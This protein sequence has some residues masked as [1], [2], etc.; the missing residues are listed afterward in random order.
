MSVC[1]E[2]E[3]RAESPGSRCVTMKNDWSRCEPPLFSPEP[4][5]SDTKVQNQRQRAE[6]PGPSCLSMKSEW[7]RHEPI[8]FSDEPGATDT[9]SHQRQGSA[10]PEPGHSCVSFKSD[11]SKDGFNFKDQPVSESQVDQQSSEVPSAQSVQQHQ[12]HLNSIFML[13]EDNIVMFVK[14]EV[15]KIQRV[16]SPD[17]PECLESQREDEEELDGEDEEQRRSSRDAFLKITVNFLRR[18]KQEELADC[19]QNLMVPVPEPRPI[20][21]YQQ[22]LQSNLQDQFVCVKPGWSEDDQRLD[23]IYTDLYITA[24]PDSHIN[25][26][27]E[28]QQLETTQQKQRSAEEPVKPSDL[29]KH[30]PGKY[31][32]IRTVLTNGIAGIGKTV[33]V[34]KFVLDWTQQ[35]SNQ[36]VHLIFPFTFRR[37]N[38]LKGQKFSLS[39]LIHECI[40]ETE[41][42]SLEALNYIFTHLQSSGNSNY[43]KS[44]FKL[45]FVFD[46]LDESRLQLDCSTS[47]K[48]TGQRDVTESTSVD[49]LLTNLIRGKLLRSARIWITTRP[50][51]ANQIHGDFVEV[52][53]EV[54]GFTDPQKEE[55]FRK[56]F[57]DE[58]QSNRI[59]SHIKTA[60]SLHIM[61]HI[62]VFCW[63]T[64]TVLEDL[65]ETRE[66]GEL[67]KTL[68]E[69]YAEFLR[70]QMDRTKDKYGPEQSRNY[71]K[72]LA[73][74][75]FKQLLKGNLIFYE[76]DLK[77]SGIDVRGASV[78]S[79]VFTEIFKQERGRKAK[80]KMFSFVHLSVQE[81]LAAVHM[82]LCY[83]NGKMEKL[84]NF[85]KYS[86]H[87]ESKLKKIKQLFV[88]P[89]THSSLDVVLSRTME[90][91]LLSPSG[92]LDLFVRFLHGL[93]LESNHRILGG[94]L[95]HTEI[96]PETIQT[97]INNLKEMNSDRISPDRSIN[98]FHC[99]MEMNDHS[100]HQQIQEFLK[101]ENRSEKELSE[102]Q[103]SALAYMLQMSEEVLDE[104]DLNQYNTSEEGRWRLIP[105]VRNCRKARLSGCG[106][107]ETHCEVV[108]SA[109][110]SNPSHLT[111]LD[112]SNN[113]LQDSVEVLCAGLKSP[114][115]RLETLRLSVCDLSERSCEA[116]SSVL[117]SQSSSLREL[118]LSNNNLQDSGVKLL[119]AGLKS[120]HCRLET[121]RLS[122]CS[123]SE[124]S[125]D[126]LVSALK[127]NLSHL[128]QLDLSNNNLQNSS[129]K[130]LCGFVE[131][132]HCRL[133]TLRLSVCDLSERS[134]E[135]LSSVLSSQSSL[136]TGDSQ[137][138]RLSALRGS[139]CLSGLSS[140]LQPLPSE[141][142]GPELQSSRRL[143]CH[144]TGRG[145]PHPDDSQAS[146]TS[147]S[148]GESFWCCR[149]DQP[150]PFHGP[151][152]GPRAAGRE[153]P[154]AVVCPILG[155]A[156]ATV[157]T[158]L[159]RAAPSYPTENR[160]PLP[161]APLQTLLSS[162]DAAELPAR[163][164]PLLAQGRPLGDGVNVPQWTIA[165][166]LRCHLQGRRRLPR[167]PAPS[168]PDAGSGDTPPQRRVAWRGHRRCC[169]VAP[170]DVGSQSHT[171]AT[172]PAT[173]PADPQVAGS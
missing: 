82:M 160:G 81:F 24:G 162:L 4:G 161:Q 51:A 112:L 113:D 69:M 168:L 17:Y 115:C 56:R 41:S 48:E 102:I 138:V 107:T 131:S 158:A 117:S 30:P 75:A 27:H 43:D 97:I 65:L 54:R 105:A 132:R 114:H 155:L 20:T 9:K 106:L 141:R 169:A 60:Q 14:K 62:P 99:L 35:R 93:C 116:L 95:G 59:M 148:D 86:K 96:S 12:T 74:L 45:L 84:D 129:V 5:A 104:L 152:G 19:L 32:R 118:D 29:F 53:T 120:P 11:W 137:A 164:S 8:N 63:I 44:S 126:S 28:V 10:G 52:V 147:A 2:E 135:A 172:L 22:M 34:N 156:L 1:V 98:I 46:G 50:A 146:R 38:P 13:L 39:E 159:R 64:A 26:Q 23:D 149:S 6:P 170:V 49:E 136:S 144:S 103:C 70:F 111:H 36:D 109:L 119:C 15:K 89:S 7:S 153:E 140:E 47:K 143:R 85:L 92:H 3:D 150:L 79:G 127:S 171:S 123:L 125:C 21:Y 121:L 80:N 91:S 88:H 16:L 87:K 31:R 110:K 165:L 58:E 67:P 76:E 157:G 167:V 61:C 142:A 77:E 134:C 73:K 128:T 139:L 42:I 71:I 124:I 154:E 101:S 72:S 133:E 40:P 163:L 57:T 37:L 145:A 55:Y 78:C 68:T 100:V 94:L 173:S 166:P 18:M 90:K 130:H 66:G 122:G 33:L 151:V 83:T 108:A 25:T